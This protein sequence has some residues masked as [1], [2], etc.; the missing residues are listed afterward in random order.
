[1]MALVIITYYL[2]YLPAILEGF[3]KYDAK[4]KFYVNKIANFLFFTNALINP[5]IY[6]GQSSEFNAAYRRVLRLRSKDKIDLNNTN[7]TIVKSS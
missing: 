3:I 5:F 6:A 1:M 4:V 7:L 2:C